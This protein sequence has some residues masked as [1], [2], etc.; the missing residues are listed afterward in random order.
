[1]NNKENCSNELVYQQPKVEVVE[2][3]VEKG[4]AASGGTDDSIWG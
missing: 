4:F 3:T 2:I 1:M